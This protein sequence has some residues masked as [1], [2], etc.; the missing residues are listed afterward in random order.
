VFRGHNRSRYRKHEFA[1][2]GLLQC[3]YDNCTV[4]AERKK[5]KY[6]YYRCSGYR[7]KCA[8]PRFREADMGVRRGQLLKD[9]YIPDTVLESLQRAIREDQ[10]RSDSWRKQERDRLQKRSTGIRARLDQAYCDKLDGEITEDFWQRKSYEW[11][12][13]KQQVLLAL[14]GLQDVAPHRVL[15]A[16]R[17]LELAHKAYFLY[18]KQNPV[19]QGKLL[20]LVLSNCAIDGASLYPTYRKP[21]DLICKAAKSEEWSGREDLNLRPPGPEPDSRAY[22]N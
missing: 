2:A 13:E 4:T 1:F 16:S 17:I 19:E 5:G 15:T 8:L 22:R 12:Q 11:Q 14:N 21:F 20:K 10:D 7:G 18:V 6:V 9:I 3:A